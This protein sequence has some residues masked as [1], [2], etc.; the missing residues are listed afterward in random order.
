MQRGKD[1]MYDIFSERYCRLSL[2]LYQFRLNISMEGFK[3]VVI[4]Q[5]REDLIGWSLCST[6]FWDK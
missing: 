3:C 5:S 2:G 4:V 1:I 6:L